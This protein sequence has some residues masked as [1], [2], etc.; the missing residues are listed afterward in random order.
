MLILNWQELVPEAIWKAYQPLTNYPWPDSIIAASIPIHSPHTL[1]HALEEQLEILEILQ[2]RI[3][4]P[5]QTDVEEVSLPLESFAIVWHNHQVSSTYQGQPKDLGL[6]LQK[7]GTW[8]SSHKLIV[9]SQREFSFPF[10]YKKNYQGNIGTVSLEIKLKID[11]NNL[12]SFV[13]TW[14]KSKSALHIHEIFLTFEAILEE[15]NFLGA[16]SYN[17]EKIFSEESYRQQI[18]ASEE[19][20]L[21]QSFQSKGLLLEIR[22]WEWQWKKARQSQEIP[23]VSPGTYNK[24]TVTQKIERQRIEKL[25]EDVEF[26][27][28]SQKEKKTSSF[29]EN[30]RAEDRFFQ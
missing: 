16:F 29:C 17:A 10:V 3:L 2:G 5:N 4:L 9:L 13:D 11:K 8:S 25:I 12:V 15:I 27:S 20:L 21:L 6:W 19:R 22:P 1:F 24:E 28:K 23:V 26:V 18:I 7:Y 30:K 14:L